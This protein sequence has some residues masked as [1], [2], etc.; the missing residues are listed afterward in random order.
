[1]FPHIFDFLGQRSIFSSITPSRVA[2]KYLIEINE[3]FWRDRRNGKH[4][5]SWATSLSYGQRTMNNGSNQIA[6]FRRKNI[7]NA[8]VWWGDKNLWV[9]LVFKVRNNSLS[10]RDDTRLSILRWIQGVNNDGEG[11]E[12]PSIWPNSRRSLRRVCS[13]VT[14]WKGIPT[15]NDNSLR[16]RISTSCYNPYHQNFGYKQILAF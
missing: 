14:V 16:M 13:R 10:I 15:H 8:L 3:I 2:G 6:T 7:C 1:M 4:T 5:Y 12:G 9:V 11:I